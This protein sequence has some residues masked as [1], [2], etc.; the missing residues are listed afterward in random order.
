[1]YI[2][3]RESIIHRLYMWTRGIIVILSN[4]SKLQLIQTS[5]IM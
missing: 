2:G 1:M 5:L 4:F 3:E